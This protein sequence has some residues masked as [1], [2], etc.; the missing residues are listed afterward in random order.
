MD[1]IGSLG[2]RRRR[3]WAK[4]PTRFPAGLPLEEVLPDSN[5]FYYSQD[6]LGS[7][8]VLTDASGDVADTDTYDP[9]GNVTA[10]TGDVQ[11]HLLFCGQYM[12]AESGLYYLQARYYDPSTA[13][14]LSFDPM[15][16]NTQTPYAYGVGDPV[17]EVDLSG[18]CSGIGCIGAII[19]AVVKSVSSVVTGSHTEAVCES[20]SANYIVGGVSEEG[21]GVVHSLVPSQW[22]SVPRR[23][24]AQALV[25]ASASPGCWA[26]RVPGRPT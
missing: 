8:R 13:Q 9:Y 2:E 26:L 24:L 12:D 19:G 16:E 6:N 22:V 3:G 7:T 25:Q 21:C 5:T 1:G 14:F 20:V 15:V 18:L 11:N 23:R 17:N 10:S 4:G